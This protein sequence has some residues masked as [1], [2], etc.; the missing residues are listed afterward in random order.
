M[1]RTGRS[2]NG[3]RSPS[4]GRNS[5]ALNLT[6]LHRGQAR[7]NHI[8][9]G[10]QSGQVMASMFILNSFQGDGG[11]HHFANSTSVA[12]LASSHKRRQRILPVARATQESA[13]P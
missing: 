9:R 11:L 7:R 8:I 1:Q 10:S 5:A 6:E 13:A 2:A 3:P 12:R 4:N